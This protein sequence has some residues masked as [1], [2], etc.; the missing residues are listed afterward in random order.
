[1]VLFTLLR[2]RTGSAATS[3]LYLGMIVSGVGVALAV[4]SRSDSPSKAR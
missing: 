2:T 1:M 3:L 4:Q